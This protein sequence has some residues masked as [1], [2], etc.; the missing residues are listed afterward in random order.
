MIFEVVSIEHRV[1]SMTSQSPDSLK[2]ATLAQLLATR[3]L[4][5]ATF[6]T[7]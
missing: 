3:Y 2:T 1:V 6:L 4:L 5:P 7:E